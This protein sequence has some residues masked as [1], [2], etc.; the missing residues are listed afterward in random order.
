MDDDAVI[1]PLPSL[2]LAPIIPNPVGYAPSPDSP[3]IDL[4]EVNSRRAA[5][6]MMTLECQAIWEAELARSPTPPPAANEVINTIL[7]APQPETPVYRLVVQPLMPPPRWV[8][9]RT[10]PP[11]PLDRHLPS[12]GEIAGWSEQF[13][14]AE[15]LT[16][17]TD[18]YYPPDWDVPVGSLPAKCLHHLVML[19]LTEGCMPWP[20]WQCRCCFN[21]GILCF[22]S[23]FTNPFG[24]HTRIPHACVHCYLARLGHCKRSIPAH[25]GM[26]YT[27]DGTPSLQPRGSHQ[28][29]RAHLTIADGYGPGLVQSDERTTDPVMTH[30]WV[31]AMQVMWHLH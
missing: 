7:L 13:V 20:S 29:E 26:D 15:L 11:P 21:L 10:P 5:P 28:V 4:Y 8:A 31:A 2:Y 9:R 27:S 23:A 19:C 14:T 25:P 30:G 22:V 12:N 16:W 6:E 3:A 18:H 24:E 1:S 17:V